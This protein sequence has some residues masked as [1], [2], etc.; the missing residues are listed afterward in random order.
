MLAH[1]IKTPELALT[2]EESEQMATAAA[3]VARHYDV[4]ASE[5]A[6]DWANLCLALGVCYGTRFVAISSRK[7]EERRAATTAQTGI[8]LAL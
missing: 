2:K 3:N 8:A 7:K 5:K 4:R 6:I 1:A